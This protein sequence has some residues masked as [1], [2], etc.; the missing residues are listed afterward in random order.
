MKIDVSELSADLIVSLDDATEVF[1]THATDCVEA[2]GMEHGQ[3]RTLWDGSVLVRHGDRIV[4]LQG[5][6]VAARAGTEVTAA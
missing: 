5:L 4:W 6:P 2:E 3:S 1:V